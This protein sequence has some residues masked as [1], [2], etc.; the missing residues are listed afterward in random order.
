MKIEFLKH[1]Y[2]NELDILI[3]SLNVDEY[4][5]D[6]E[7]II[8]NDCLTHQIVT[9]MEELK[10]FIRTKKDDTFGIYLSCHQK[11]TRENINDGVYFPFDFTYQNND[12]IITYSLGFLKEKILFINI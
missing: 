9:E 1:D 2:E 4:H 5:Y 6:H 12:L 10:L 11:N 8:F 3:Y 7:K